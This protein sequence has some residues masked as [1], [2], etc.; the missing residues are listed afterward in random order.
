MTNVVIPF[1]SQTVCCPPVRRNKTSVGCCAPVKI[2]DSIAALSESDRM[3]ARACPA[4]I[5]QPGSL[6]CQA[7]TTTQAVTQAVVP[8]APPPYVTVGTT[9]ASVTTQ[10][11]QQQAVG[12]AERFSQYFRPA[13]LC[14]LV[15]RYPSTD[16]KPSVNTCLPI[17]RFT[18]VA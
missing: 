2:P 11:K 8:G 14:P 16:P 4:F 17:R 10:M 15:V 3:A 18:G 12:A 6:D 9:P 13:P 7:A 1:A 5:R